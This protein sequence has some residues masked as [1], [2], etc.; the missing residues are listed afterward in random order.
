MVIDTGTL[1]TQV[2][3]DTNMSVTQMFS[4]TGTLV[5]QVV[6]DTNMSVTQMVSDKHIS[7]TSGY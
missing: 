1:V 4:D 6:I 2:V 5:T 7:D 3:I